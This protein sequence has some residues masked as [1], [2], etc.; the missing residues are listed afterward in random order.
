MTRIYNKTILKERRR[1]LRHNQTDAEKALWKHLRNKS[2]RGLKFFRQYSVS[3]YIIDF[4]CP[5]Y[6][7]AAELDGGQHAEKENKEYDRARTANLAS[8]GIKIIRFW[9]NDVLRNIEGVLEEI[10]GRLTPPPSAPPL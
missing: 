7:I 5:E 6:K 2:F 10:T 1:E 4:Y 8:L 9:N 3:A